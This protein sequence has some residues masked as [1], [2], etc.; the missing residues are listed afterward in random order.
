MP[1][2]AN[3]L[4]STTRADFSA[5]NKRTGAAPTT[6]LTSVPASISEESLQ[7]FQ[8]YQVPPEGGMEE[9]VEF[10]L[11]SGT[12]IA[13]GDVITSVVLLTDGTTLWPGIM[14]TANFVLGVV[15][16]RETAPALLPE[17]SVRAK[18]T[19]LK[20]QAHN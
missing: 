8:R 17:R 6:V 10:F 19:V 12:N 7:A 15:Y 14:P 3:V 2:L 13:F 11:D 1:L 16:V 9:E 4:I 18:R 5:P 20:G